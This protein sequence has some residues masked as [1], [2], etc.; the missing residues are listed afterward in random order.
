[1]YNIQ[2]ENRFLRLIFLF[3]VIA[4][5]PVSRFLSSWFSPYF[6]S[7][8]AF[9][10]GAVLWIV[11]FIIIRILLTKKG[12]VRLESN[13]LVLSFGDHTDEHVPLSRS[14]T[15]RDNF[16]MNKKPACSV[17]TEGGTKHRLQFKNEAERDEF[18]A[19]VKEITQMTS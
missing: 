13:N 6:G 7:E 4:Y 12:T 9:F 11:L 10:G 1:M 14:V 3:W 15:I 17:Q 19:K 8:N 2:T 16:R 5:F 18:V